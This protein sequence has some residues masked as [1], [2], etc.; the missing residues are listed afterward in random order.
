MHQKTADEFRV[1]QRDL[2]SWVPRFPAPGREGDVHF[3]D[4]QDPAV[5]DGD[6]MG[7]TAEIFDGVPK[8]VKGF[9]DVRAPVLTVKGIPEFRPMVRVAQFF[10]GGGKVQLPIPEEGLET[11]EEL[12]FELIPE[13][14]HPDKEVFLHSPDLMV[15]GNAAA[16]NDAVHMH[17][18]IEFLV[19]GMED[20]NDAGR[21]AE[22]L[23]VGGKFQEGIRA[24]PVEK[25]VKQGLVG[26]KERVEL[27][28]QGEYHVEIRGIDHLCPAFINPEF[29]LDSLAI[30]AAAVTAG[31]V[32]YFDMPAFRALADAVT[33]P[34]GLAV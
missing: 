22:M 33:E 2:P 31:V 18:V 5:G 16:G 14:L 3:R 21:C 26:V 25:A 28:R 20:L 8:T 34:A 10:T 30:G 19:P 23:F 15:R 29:F 1:F 13:G 9:F 17:M 11:R 12:A 7:V 32:V 4:G 27:M 6:L 24:A